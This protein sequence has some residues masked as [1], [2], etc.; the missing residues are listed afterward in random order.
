MNRLRLRGPPERAA[1]AA[2]LI[3]EACR[4]GLPASDR[5]ILIRRLDLGR[6]VT[7]GRQAE[8]GYALR[9]VYDKATRGARH[10][11]DDGAAAANCVWFESRAEA[12][13]LLLRALL[14]GRRP[15]GWFW[16]LA[17]PE[18]QDGSLADWLA[19][20][21]P[22]AAADEE[23]G[24]FLEL[25]ALAVEGGAAEA[26]IEALAR[27][28]G[29]GGVGDRPRPEPPPRHRAE[30]AGTAG[31]P[32]RPAFIA[33][34]DASLERLRAGLDVALVAATEKLA[35]RL[36]PASRPATLL[37][38]RL[39]VRASPPLSLS[40]TLLDRLVRAYAEALSAPVR[41]LQPEAGPAPAIRRPG[42]A[43]LPMSAVAERTVKSEAAA[44]SAR[45]RTRERQSPRS[46]PSR[47]EG[48][49][50]REP[51]PLAARRSAEIA[52]PAAG[53]WLVIPSLIRLG[54]REWLADRPDLL[55]TD[56]GRLLLR[57]IA[58]H[59]RVPPDDPA[60]APL[61]FDQAGFAPPGWARLWR[62]ALDRWLRRR[63]GV[64]LSH[65]VWRPG[66]LRFADD[67]LTVR[68]PLAAADIRLRRRALDVDPGWTDWLGLS[69]RY[70]FAERPLG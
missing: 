5:L 1:K 53:L 20:S 55:A 46:S 24:D 47:A 23:G 21:L 44:A 37:L 42:E 51:P 8:R 70:A 17:V 10:G 60:L 22:A 11:G 34:P 67:R 66:W 52:S 28:P 36:G 35:R 38:E 68:F 56:P 50:P 57:T 59:H 43:R 54:W 25:V 64:G 26:I 48:P 14:A 39:L 2:F 29:T 33:D 32:P 61:A 62:T 58:A 63:A 6:G 69:V 9:R 41:R 30:T 13:R 18:W 27:N 12:R 40:R 49:V 65:L 45:A 15:A 3:E 7:A 4:T 31:P 19:R 16:R